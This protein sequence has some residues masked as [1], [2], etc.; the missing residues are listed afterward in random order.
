MLC[1]LTVCLNDGRFRVRSSFVT[2]Q[3]SGQGNAVMLTD[4]TGYFSFFQAANVELVVK[5]LDA[6]DTSFNRFWVFAAGLTDVEVELEVTDTQEGMILT[7]TN[8]QGSAFVPIQDT[9]AFATCP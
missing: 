6:C 5:V 9:D 1:A 3:D 7:Y 8:P 4:D 2:S